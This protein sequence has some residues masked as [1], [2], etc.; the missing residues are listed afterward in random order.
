MNALKELLPQKALSDQT[1]APE[2]SGMAPVFKDRDAY[3]KL[4]LKW[5]NDSP[6]KLKYYDCPICHNKGLIAYHGE[7]YE[8]IL[9]TCECM[10]IRNSVRCMNESGLGG[11]LER[12]TFDAYETPQEWQ[13]HAKR[14]V[15]SYL[16]QDSGRWLYVAGQSGCGKTHLCTAVCRAL[17]EQG[18][19][20]RYYLWR[21]L[22]RELT[23]MQYRYEDYHRRMQELTSAE[24]LYLDD[25]LKNLDKNALGRELSTAYDLIQARYTAGRRTLISSELFLTEVSAL[26]AATGGRIAESAR[27]FIVQMNRGDGR[28]YR[29]R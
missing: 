13:A 11:M 27:G 1:A 22:C 24:I 3:E 19:A 16:G 5:Y 14:R 12:C 26:D 4:R 9:R 18:H 6:G 28:N 29:F 2:L 8:Q 10:K 7:D 20:V 21:D 23:S 17:M 25:F 15:M